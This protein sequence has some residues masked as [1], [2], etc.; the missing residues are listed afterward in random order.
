MLRNN[1][2]SERKKPNLTTKMNQ[3]RGKGERGLGWGGHAYINEM[4]LT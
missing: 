1:L 3:L 2:S 4:D